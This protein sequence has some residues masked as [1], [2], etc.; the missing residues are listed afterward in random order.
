MDIEF[1]LG[2]IGVLERV[3]GITLPLEGGTIRLRG[4]DFINSG[5]VLREFGRMEEEDSLSLF[6]EKH[7]D[8]PVYERQEAVM[9]ERHLMEAQFPGYERVRDGVKDGEVI[10]DIGCGSGIAGR[11]FFDGVIKRAWYVAIDM[12]FAVDKAKREFTD[13]G[14]RAGYVQAKIE[15]LPFEDGVADYV[16]CPGVLHYAPDVAQA[17]GQC[18]RLL[19]PGGRLITWI[20][21]KQKPLRALTDDY[22]RSIFSKMGPEE[23]FEKMESLT[24]L[25]IA[26]GRLNQK[27]SLEEDI[28]CLGIKAGTYDLHELIYYHFIKLFFRQGMSFERHNL[29]NWNAYCPSPVHFHTPDEIMKMLVESG[30]NPTHWN[31]KGNGIGLMATRG[32]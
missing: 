30:L 9:F 2:G 18:A 20:Y 12:S 15:D 16:F 26:L 25:G 32:D 5:G 11:S 3:M 27:I 7:W 22:L 4:I 6:Y 17:I 24:K 23:A 19:K 31:D 13:R 8:N 14:M 10:L 21:Q 1:T 28:E 29:N